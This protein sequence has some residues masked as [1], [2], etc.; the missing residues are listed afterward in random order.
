MN[1]RRP[2]VKREATVKYQL[3]KL[4]VITLELL[5]NKILLKFLQLFLSY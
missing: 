2:K 5:D 1:H 4:D 3:F